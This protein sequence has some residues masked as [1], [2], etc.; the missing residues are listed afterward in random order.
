ML[1]RPVLRAIHKTFA[2]EQTQVEIWILKY[3]PISYN[4]KITYPNIMK[5][6]FVPLNHLT[7]RV[8]DHQDL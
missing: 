7:L 4:I 8:M 5:V 3:S 2:I 1:P 6:L